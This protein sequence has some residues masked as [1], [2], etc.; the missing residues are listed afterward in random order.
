MVLKET[1]VSR[2]QNHINGIEGFWSLA[3]HWLYQYCGISKTYFPLYLKEVGWQ[4]NH[5]NENLVVLLHRLLNQQILIV[6]EQS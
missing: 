6:K 1:R 5:Q 4:F 2:G 3:K